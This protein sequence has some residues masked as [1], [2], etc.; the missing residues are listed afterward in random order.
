MKN[1]IFMVNIKGNKKLNRTTP[2]EYSIK[3]WKRWADKN[4]CELFVLEDWV[5]DE[6]IINP[7]WHKLLV[8]DLLENNEVDYNQILVVDSDT[9]PHPNCPNFFDMSENKL[10]GVHNDGSYDWVCRSMENYSKHIF[11]GFTFPIWEYINSGF[12]IVNKNHKKLYQKIMKF[13]L[14]NNEN[15]RILQ[16]SFGVGTD[17]PVINFFIQKEK[18]DMKLLSYKFNM[19]DMFRKEILTDDLLF[20]KLGWVYHFNA[21]P[22]NVDSQLTIQWMKKTY[23]HFYGN[24]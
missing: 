13:Y 9:I 11:D 8:F 12:L 18:I 5:Y 7:N 19:Q 10:C 20:T 22:N 4:N 2:Y 15:I 21:I 14:E 1:V 23:E 17:Q 24:K 6:S 3:S 16:E